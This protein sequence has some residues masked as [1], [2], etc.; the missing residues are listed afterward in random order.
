MHPTQIALSF[1][2]QINRHEVEGLAAL[3]TED[4]V[5]V[6]ALGA[7]V[8]GRQ[9]M[10]KAW[11]GYFAWFPDYTI[12]CTDVLEKGKVVALFGAACATYSAGGKPAPEDR[13]EAPAAWKVVVRGGRVAEWRVYVDNEP[14][15]RIMAAHKGA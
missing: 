8:Q 3:M 7:R 11:S 6:D 14:A 4:H 1:V 9:A 5:F 2:E 10:R 15:R 12:T 13:W